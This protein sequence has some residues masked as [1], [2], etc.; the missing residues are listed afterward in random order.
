M[1]LNKHLL[2]KKGEPEEYDVEKIVA[3]RKDGRK[4]FDR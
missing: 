1:I 3:E 2:V 4:Y